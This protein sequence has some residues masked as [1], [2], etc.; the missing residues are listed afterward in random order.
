MKC[1]VGVHDKEAEKRRRGETWKGK[2]VRRG[3]T[4]MGGS[5]ERKEAGKGRIGEAVKQIKERREAQ[6][7][8]KLITQGGQISLGNPR[9]SF[10]CLRKARKAES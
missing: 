8:K 7:R 9:L 2:K 4:E 3:E 1:F 10:T 6:G 5:R